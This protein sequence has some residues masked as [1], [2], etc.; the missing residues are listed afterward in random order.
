MLYI[1]QTLIKTM[2]KENFCPQK[3]YHINILSDKKYPASEY[4]LK[5]SY[6]ETQC[7]GSA[8]GGE[9]INDLP[10]LKSGAKTADHQRI[11][12]QVEKFKELL[13]EYNINIIQ[14]RINLLHEHDSD[15][16][17]Y[18][19]IDFFGSIEDNELGFVPFAAID[20]K[21]T[22]SIHAQ[23]GDFC[24]AY[25]YNMDHTQARMY[26]YLI[27]KN[28]QKKVPFYYMVFD[29]KP[30]P[31][32]KIIRKK[33]EP[34]DELEFSEALRKTQEKYRYYEAVRWDE[35]RPSAE[36]CSNCPLLETCKVA[37]RRQPIEVI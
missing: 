37:N 13:K 33:I 34:L 7:L 5:G 30:N 29:Y 35:Y 22:A 2:A 16:I 17:L 11:D 8:T 3:V 4:M 9:T 15:T 19:E 32:Y 27:E 26:S 36:N 31:E 24:W 10:R 12:Q 21:L 14:K 18:G 28:I 25:P 23:Y 1:N 6:F 20:L